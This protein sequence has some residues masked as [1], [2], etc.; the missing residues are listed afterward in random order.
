MAAPEALTSAL[1]LPPPP[2]GFSYAMPA[3]TLGFN[4]EL[5]NHNN[6]LQMAWAANAALQPTVWPAT[7]N[8]N[9]AAQKTTGDGERRAGGDRSMPCRRL[10]NGFCQFG[11]RCWFSH[12][13]SVGGGGGDSPTARG[14]RRG[15]CH[16]FQRQL[17][18]RGDACPFLHE[19]DPASGKPCW[20]FLKS[21]SCDFRNCRF[22]HL[23][24]DEVRAVE[25]QRLPR[26]SSPDPSRPHDHSPL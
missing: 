10:Q 21:G 12:D 2:A 17:C 6:M 1:G 25:P 7:P 19:K 9:T 13:P 11:D 22:K 15:Y 4:A 8:L 23:S 26:S 16:D 18:M 20:Q 3:P 24:D 14:V 5:A